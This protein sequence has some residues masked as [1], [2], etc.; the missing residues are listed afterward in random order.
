MRNHVRCNLPCTTLHLH[1]RPGQSQ[2]CCTHSPK[3]VPSFFFDPQLRF[4]NRFTHHLATTYVGIFRSF[5][6][7]HK[8]TGCP[9]FENV[10]N[11]V[12][13]GLRQTNIYQGLA[14]LPSREAQASPLPGSARASKTRPWTDATDQEGQSPA[15]LDK[16]HERT[17]RIA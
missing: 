14:A 13:V 16:A 6:M 11:T 3:Q 12:K 17:S 8:I 4:H 15:Q 7:I 10:N 5:Y 9:L 2:P 1:I